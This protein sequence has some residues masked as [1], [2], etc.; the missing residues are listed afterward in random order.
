[1]LFIIDILIF[2]DIYIYIYNV[3]VYYKFM[4]LIF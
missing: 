2:Y 4:L 1:M 3:V